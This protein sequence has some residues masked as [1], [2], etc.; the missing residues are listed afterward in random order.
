MN[1]NIDPKLTRRL[2]ADGRFSSFALADVGASGGIAD[3]WRSFGDTLHATGFD[4]LIR[5]VARLNAS[6][7]NRNVQYVAASVGYKKYKEVFPDSDWATKPN[8]SPWFRT[9]AVRAQQVTGR[10]F[11]ETVYDPSGALELSSEIV[12]LDQ[13]FANR[14]VDFLKTDTD[15]FDIAVLLGARRLLAAAPVIAVQ[16]EVQ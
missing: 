2:V 13:Y 16:A 10:S 8:G 3:R 15:G 9:S 4:P 7:R 14:P 6:E 12:E 1:D 11:A 5:E